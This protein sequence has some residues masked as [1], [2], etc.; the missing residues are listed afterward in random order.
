MQY[1]RKPYYYLILNDNAYFISI[2]KGIKASHHDLN[3]VVGY[4][5][6]AN[7]L[8]EGCKNAN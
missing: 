2:L 7:I 3:L 4:R 8:T 1:K 5:R 6:A